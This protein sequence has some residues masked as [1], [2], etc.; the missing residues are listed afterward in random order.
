MKTKYIIGIC[1]SLFLW[2]NT[3]AQL[4]KKLKKRAEQAAERTILDKT[5]EAVTKTTENTIDGVTNGKNQ[6]DSPNPI[7]NSVSNN[8]ALTKNTAEKKAFYTEDVIIKMHENDNLNQIQYFD[9]DEVAARIESNKLPQPGYNDSEGFLYTFESDGYKKS[10]LIAVQSQGMMVP[11]MMLEAYKLPPEPF[12]AQLQKQTDQGLTA[13]PFNGIVEFAFIYRP[14]DF[15]YEDFKESKQSF[16]GKTYTRFD[17]LNEPG[18]EGSYVLFDENNRLVEIY[19][20]KSE[21]SQNN[22]LEMNMIGPAGKS[23]LEYSYEPVEVNLPE[24]EEVKVAGQGMM[25][26]MMGSFKKNGDSKID[27]DDYDTSDSKG[28]TKSFKNSINNHKVTADMLPNSYEFD[29]KYETVMV[30]ESRKKDVI[31]LTFLL[32]KDADY[33]ATI[34]SDSKNKTQGNITMVMDENLNTMVMFMDGQGNKIVQL[35]PIP[36]ANNAQNNPNFKITEL[37]S[38][39]I[40]GYLCKGIQLENDKYI[41]KLYHAPD[42]PISLGN[43]L[44]FSGQKKLNLPDLDPQ[45]V[46]QFSNGLVMEMQFEDKKKSKNNF[47]IIAKSLQKSP[48]KINKNEYQVMDFFAGTNTMKN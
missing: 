6:D 42:T 29:W 22:A 4:L 35:F 44:S 15:R 23:L 31:N 11:T 19:T 17:Y 30:M 25:E 27:N 41:A 5:D 40:L 1:C 2:T 38:K 16:K 34:M 12:M 39:T 45:M 26:M 46:N 20:N 48:S 14:D 37:P 24:A 3:E 33:Q 43:F 10:S 21:T 13:N 28:M 9:A 36:L 32:R 7:G 18:Y 47:S 8:S